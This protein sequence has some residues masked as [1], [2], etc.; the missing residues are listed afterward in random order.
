LY[1]KRNWS[2]NYLNYNVQNFNIE[3]RGSLAD[4]AERQREQC[5]L[6]DAKPNDGE[7]L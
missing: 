2:Q 1:W 6:N 3:E 7:L 4:V 5:E